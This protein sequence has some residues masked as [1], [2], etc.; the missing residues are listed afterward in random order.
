MERNEIFGI[1][2][3]RPSKKFEDC[4][5]GE[6]EN[7]YVSKKVFHHDEDEIIFDYRYVVEVC[8][9]IEEGK[10]Y[11][12]LY[13]VIAPDS[14][15]EENKKSIRELIGI[16]DEDDFSYDDIISCGGCDVQLGCEI[17]ESEKEVHEC[18][19]AIANVYE[20]MDGLFGFY[21]DKYVNGIGTTGWDVIKHAVLNHDLF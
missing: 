10:F 8:D 3:E 16:E 19:E 13:M 6:A 18:L 12:I 2:C 20:F 5:E 21:M 9:E 17:V 15:H 14:L 4:F 1:F 11:V 7:Y